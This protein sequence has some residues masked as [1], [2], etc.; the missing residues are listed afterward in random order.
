MTTLHLQLN[1]II[2]PLMNY[3]RLFPRTNYYPLSSLHS[4]RRVCAQG[5]DWLMDGSVWRGKGRREDNLISSRLWKLT[6]LFVRQSIL[7]RQSRPWND[8]LGI[9]WE[10]RKWNWIIKLLL[11]HTLFVV[12]SLHFVSPLLL[13]LPLRGK[14]E[15]RWRHMMDTNIPIGLPPAV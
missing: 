14:L 4:P 10:K 5:Q 3:F 7:L 12:I 2:E 13:L 11:G 6:I 8:I 1:A 15:Y 9:I